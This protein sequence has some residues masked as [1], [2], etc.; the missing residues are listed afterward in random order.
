MRNLFCAAV[1]GLLLVIVTFLASSAMASVPAPASVS[2]FQP[3]LGQLDPRVAFTAERDGIT[4]FVTRNGELVHRF[5]GSDGRDWVM[6]ERLHGAQ[7]MQPV[8]VGDDVTRISVI[9]SDGTRSASTT[10]RII[11]G[12][13]W[14]GIRAELWLTNDQFEKRFELEVGVDANAIRI[15]LDGVEGI[16]IADDGQLM[17]TTGPGDIAMSAPVAW[18]DINGQQIAVPVAYTLADN[19]TYGF[20]LGNHDTDY[21]VTIDPVI[22]STFAGSNADFEGFAFISI[23]STSVYAAGSS[24]SNN[25]PGLSGGFQPM[26][27]STSAYQPNHLIARFNLDLTTL[28]QVTF[29]GKYG[30]VPTPTNTTRAGLEL[31]GLHA[32]DSGVFI[33]GTAPGHGDHVPTTTGAFQETPNGGPY[34][35]STNSPPHDVFVARLSP[36]LTQLQ[37]GTY[38]G[39]DKSE[40]VWN[41]TVGSDGVYVTGYANAPVLPGSENGANPTPLTPGI[42]TFVAK[43]SLNLDQALSATWISRGSAIMTPYAIAL[44]G[45]GSVYV[46]GSGRG[47]LVDTTGAYQPARTGLSN[48]DEG[49]VVH[50]SADLAT[51][52]R[53]TFLGGTAHERI[54]ELWFSEGNLYVAGDTT[55]SSTFPVPPDAA[56]PGYTYQSPFVFALSA[57][58]TTRVGATYFAGTTYAPGKHTSIGRLASN[59]GTIYFAG[60]TR[61]STLPGTLGGVQ[62]DNTGSQPCGYVAAFNPSLTILKQATYIACGD[63]E[64]Q[65]ADVAFANDTLYLTGSTK[66]VT[67]PGS[68]TG[69]QPQNAGTNTFDG[70]ILA[71]TGDLGGPKPNADLAVE[72]TGSPTRIANRYVRYWVKVTNNGP[73]S[74]VDALI[75]DTLPPELGASNWTCTAFNGANCPNASGSGSIAETATLPNDGRLEYEL[76]ALATSGA[77]N[78]L[79]VAKATVASHTLDPVS[80]NNS[81]DAV[82]FDP[83]L[84]ADGFEDTNLP[85]L[86]PP[87]I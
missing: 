51:H 43:L 75:E 72:K 65:V 55:S 30:D 87:G 45:D 67:L 34:N 35:N 4:L 64:V 18:Q 13:P 69:A 29:Y 71:T 3:N 53:A 22:R 48:T 20:T 60:T 79:N 83:R 25:F 36:D 32:T 68:G 59:D 26:R 77:T 16:T 7:S 85:P 38:Y 44:G 37:A 12:E 74:A 73:D 76:C 5:A 46:G 17:L 42:G 27:I 14:P 86:C 58:L 2:G 57:D 82:L 6:I 40:Q 23:N 84:F 80:G 28:H 63:R 66:L 1:C 39:T 81:D 54:E 21:P 56:V 47:D 9:D 19:N 8:A 62:V 70:F 49:F 10:R 50:L 24:A 41:M 78:I 15:S 52:H 33:A 11:I 31:R 61:S